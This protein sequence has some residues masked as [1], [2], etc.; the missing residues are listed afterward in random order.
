METLVKELLYISRS[1][2]NGGNDEF[3]TINLAE[4][5][6]VQ[7]AEVT[8][9]FLEKKQT[10][11]VVIPDCILCE[12]IRPQMERAVQNI[13]VNAIRHSPDGAQIKVTISAFHGTVHCKV[14]N[15]GIH[16]PDETLPHLFEAFYRADYSRNRGTGGTGLGLYIVKTV[17]ENHHA[18][19]GI[20]NTEQGV[21]FWF[22]LPEKEM[23]ISNSI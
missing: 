11:D 18:K 6:R 13:I 14:E 5:F 20:K 21:M 4:I 15:T 17:M 2:N 9:L 7:I 10:F 1:E 12:M 16:V 8:D 19:Y 22:D 23:L 3:E